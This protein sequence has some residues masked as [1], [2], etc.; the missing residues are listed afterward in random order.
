MNPPAQ[1]SIPSFE[2]ISEFF[3]EEGIR[4]MQWRVRLPYFPL[5]VLILKIFKRCALLSIKE[6]SFPK[7]ICSKL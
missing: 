3:W 5:G 1:F 7:K 4:K 6:N 2:M